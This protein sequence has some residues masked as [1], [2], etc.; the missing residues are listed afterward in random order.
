M[1]LELKLIGK[2]HSKGINNSWYLTDPLARWLNHT[3]RYTMVEKF[4][5]FLY[6]YLHRIIE[7]S[8]QYRI[9]K[10]LI[11]F[12]V[13]EVSVNS[14]LVSLIVY[15]IN[16]NQVLNLGYSNPCD[17]SLKSFF[18]WFRSKWQT[19]MTWLEIKLLQRRFAISSMSLIIHSILIH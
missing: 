4:F 6:C 8:F 9:R 5:L 2:P 19:Y 11:C 18:K 1:C 12:H 13:L 7:R 17:K 14:K 16:W 15:K 10:V 3:V